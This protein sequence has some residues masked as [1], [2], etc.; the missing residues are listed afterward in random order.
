LREPLTMPRN[1]A[2]NNRR[3]GLG[4]HDFVPQRQDGLR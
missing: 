1:L 3:G 4:L 2:G